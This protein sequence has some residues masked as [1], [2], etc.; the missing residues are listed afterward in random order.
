MT[1]RLALCA[2]LLV[3]AVPLFA[4]RRRA[5]QPGA[6]SRCAFSS[7]P[8]AVDADVNMMVRD[9]THLYW[10]DAFG[11]TLRRVPLDGGAVE[12]LADLS[13]WVP[14]DLTIDDTHL[15]LT[16]LTADATEEV[17]EGDIV[18]VPKGGGTPLVLRSRVQAAFD[19]EVDATHIYWL[20]AGTLDFNAETQPADGEVARMRKDGTGAET[21]AADLAFPLDLALDGDQV[22]FG[23]TGNP[24]SGQKFGL[25]RVAKSGGAVVTLNER[26][27]VGQLTVL[28][29]SLL[30]W[31]AG[32]VTPNGL[33]RIAKDGTNLRTLLV[34]EYVASGA[35]VVGGQAYTLYTDEERNTYGIRRIDLANPSAATIVAEGL[36]IV[37]FEVDECSVI[38]SDGAR[39]TIVRQAR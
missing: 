23:Q 11:P 21:L 3:V 28:P 19:L 22:Y 37:D 10:V 36:Y 35:S 24:L 5:V 38:F 7:T 26:I 2:L 13:R 4:G 16:T 20:S 34:D 25:F 12:E 14:F 29:D 6:P 33:F 39:G 32:D 17:F 8:L 9:A 1:R 15:Y 30:F 18:S 27:I 31:G